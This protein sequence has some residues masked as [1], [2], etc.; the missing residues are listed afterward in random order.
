MALMKI[1]ITA[2]AV[3]SDD[4]RD[5]QQHCFVKLIAMHAVGG[6]CTIPEA[7]EHYRIWR[8]ALEIVGFGHGR[9][10]RFL[11]AE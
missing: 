7:G 10:C 2:R 9:G 6:Q 4:Q 1:G 5:L 8:L 11:I 3:A